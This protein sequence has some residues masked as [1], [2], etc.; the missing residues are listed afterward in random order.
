M[1][2]IGIFGGTFNPI[3]NGHIRLVKEIYVKADL[4]F[5][6]LV[7]DNLPPHKEFEGDVTGEDRLF[8]CRQA[9]AE[10]GE[11]KFRTSDIELKR[12]GKSYTVDTLREM[13]KIYPED[14][15]YLIVGSDMLYTFCEW[16]EW[17]EILKLANIC[18]A[19]RTEGE[20]EELLKKANE[21][22]AF[23]GKV[24][25]YDVTPFEI[26]SKEIRVAASRG[27]DI[28]NF[29]PKRVYDFIKEKRLYPDKYESVREILKK[30]LKEKR[31]IHSENVAIRAVELAKAYG[32]DEELEEKAYFCG[33]IH[34]ICKNIPEREQYEIAKGSDLG[35]SD[36]ELSSTALYHSKA[37][38]AYIKEK[39]GITDEDEI[40]A[41]R[42]HTEGR[43]GMSKL[44]KA[45]Y[46]ADL[47]SDDRNYPD[48]ERMRKISEENVDYAMKEALE[49]IVGD[50]IKRG[51]KPSRNTMDAY[52]EFVGK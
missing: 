6:I 45:V 12:G 33:L 32:F 15:F 1:R 19:G 47:T 27:I 36:D 39:L 13:K 8:M 3:H 5:I 51:K 37:G 18:A 23:G 49:F 30:K 14:E 25:I 48:V 52:N 35:I 50:L 10:L 34:D 28:G 20:Q 42:Y 38:A 22:K 17:K 29:V 44:E 4:D 40:N 7:P 24:A 41:V 31:Y 46:L 9:C 16:K 11:G 43:G 26:S 2:K 21:L